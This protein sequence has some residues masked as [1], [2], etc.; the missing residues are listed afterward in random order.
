MP[1]AVVVLTTAEKAVC[2]SRLKGC[3]LIITVTLSKR[4]ASNGSI[5]QYSGVFYKVNIIENPY[6]TLPL[7][8]GE[9]IWDGEITRGRN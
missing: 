8:K 2:N 5:P 6:P 1:E 9:G 4:S 7:E 3:A